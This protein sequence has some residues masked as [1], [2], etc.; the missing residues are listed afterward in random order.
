MR[1]RLYAGLVGIPVLVLMVIG[2]LA[3]PG[4][5]DP[6]LPNVPTHRHWLGDPFNGGHQI[7][8]NVC[9]NPNV[10]KAFNQFHFNIHHSLIPVPAGGPPPDGRIPSNGPQDGAPGL[11]NFQG[12][13]LFITA[14][15]PDRCGLP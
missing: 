8:P 10:Q 1:K 7:G 15:G 6:N 3:G 2:V 4:A 11:H 9:D 12:G 5:A 13:E 14:I